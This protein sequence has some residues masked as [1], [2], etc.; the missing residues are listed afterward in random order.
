[1]HSTEQPSNADSSSYPRFVPVNYSMQN[2][3]FRFARRRCLA[4][5]HE[6]VADALIPLL[7]R[8]DRAVGDRNRPATQN[9]V[10]RTSAISDATREKENLMAH[11][12]AWQKAQRKHREYRGWRPLRLMRGLLPADT[13]VTN[14]ADE[15]HKSLMSMKYVGPEQNFLSSSY[16]SF[17]QWA[18]LQIVT[19]RDTRGFG[20]ASLMSML[21]YEESMACPHSM[22]E[23][24]ARRAQLSDA[25]HIPAFVGENRKRLRS[26]CPCWAHALTERPSSYIAR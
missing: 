15:N 18:P 19:S 17:T 25:F 4:S 5:L 11:S 6:D 24:V 14:H 8:I 10:H 22:V 2:N 20:R 9:F 16:H 12:Q 23:R 3:P 21:R 26:G 7:M 13:R 1:M